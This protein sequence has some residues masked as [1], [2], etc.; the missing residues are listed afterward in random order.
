[1]LP[2]PSFVYCSTFIPDELNM[3]VTG[4]KDKTLRVWSQTEVDGEYDV[5]IAIILN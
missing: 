5:S 3:I 4:G 1:M 2:H